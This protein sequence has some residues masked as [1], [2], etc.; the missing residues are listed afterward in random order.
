MISGGGGS[1]CLVSALPELLLRHY[2]IVVT[3]HAAAQEQRA[4]KFK[5]GKVKKY[6]NGYLANAVSA[7]PEYEL[8]DTDT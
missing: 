3:I 6:F 4:E 5:I 1:H 8:N 2:K 7:I